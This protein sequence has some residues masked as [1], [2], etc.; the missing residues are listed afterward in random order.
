MDESPGDI[1]TFEALA[2]DPEIA[3]LLEFE[4]VPRKIQRA[5]C[6]FP[7][8]QREL[9]ARIA[10]TGR[11]AEAVALMGK[12][13]TGAKNLYRHP[14]AGSFRAAW[15]AAEKLGRRRNGLDSRPCYAGPIP[16]IRSPGAPASDPGEARYVPGIPADL[17]ER[18]YREALDYERRAQ[19]RWDESHRRVRDKIFFCRRMYLKT[20]VDDPERRAAWE[21]LCGPADW[22]A[23]RE[24]GKQPDEDREPVSVEE[25]ETAS[26]QVPL[27]T[28]FCVSITD[29][30]RTLAAN[31]LQRLEESVRANDP[32]F[33]NSSPSRSDGEGD[34]SK[35][36][37]GAEGTNE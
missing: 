12:Q 25:L 3:P 31:T 5:D 9:V 32:R 15:D 2:A 27:K 26:W 37:R 23:A 13:L 8:L 29:A 17:Q 18:D 33:A 10:A 36:G 19:L 4:P 20:I 1:P 24:L 22:E 11:P 34:H 14:D 16:G 21:L 30:G 28:G 35:N 7:E 6:W